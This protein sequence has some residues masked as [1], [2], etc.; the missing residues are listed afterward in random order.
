M[1]RILVKAAKGAFNVLYKLGRKKER[2]DEVAFLSRQT[3]APSYD[4][5]KLAEEFRSRGW[6]VHMHLTKVKGRNLVPYAFHVLKEIRL[7]GRCKIAIIDRYDP[8]ICLVDFECEKVDDARSGAG[9]GAVAGSGAASR[10]VNLSYPTRPV[11]LQLWH[12]FGAFKKFG[13]QSVGTPEGHSADFTD[14]FDI[15]RNYS[16]VVCSG[17]GA[18]TGFA[19]AFSCLPE[20]V[21]A[22]DRPEYD[23]LAERAAERA[24]L[25][26]KDQIERPFRVLIAPTLRINDESAHPVRALYE[27]KEAFE[28]LLRDAGGTGGAGEANG[29]SSSGGTAGADSATDAASA[30]R[31]FDVCWSFH[32]LE[33]GLPAPGNVS[34]QLLSCDCL[35]TD[36]SSIVYEAYLLGI[37]TLFYIPDIASYSVSPGLN[38]NPAQLCPGLCA[39]DERKLAQLV[40]KIA[41]NPK[42]YPQSEFES[43]AASAFD[44][45]VERTGSAAARLVDFLIANLPR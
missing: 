24:H 31:K 42:T 15:H 38:S 35:V 37:P 29:A 4:F 7:L 17:A 32:P 19:E 43:F 2:V 20:R 14:T 27:H 5:A 41:E 22:M 11:V 18:R 6:K 3:N 21:I 36:Y 10:P 8:V 28:A 1:R 44:I 9:K 16:W 13:H 26:E 40:A 25:R 12:A 34:D 23:E 33:A 39:F 30:T 45:D